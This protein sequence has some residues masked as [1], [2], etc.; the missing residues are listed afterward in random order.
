MPAG[1]TH[2]I[3]RTA[4]RNFVVMRSLTIL[5]LA[6]ATAGAVA[7][8]HSAVP[9][10]TAAVTPSGGAGTAAGRHPGEPPEAPAA[11][12]GLLGEYDAPAGM[13]IALE[14]GGRLFFADTVRHRAALS[15]TGEHQFTITNADARAVLGHDGTR[16]RFDVD[17]SGRATKAWLDDTPMAR[18]AI[19]PAPGT[20][21]LQVK[22]VRSVAE[23]RTEAL[24]ATPPHENGT[25]RPADLVELTSL[26]PTIRLE[27]RYATTNNFLGTKFYD[28]A[29]AFMQRP[30]AE[31]VVR[32]NASLKSLGYG[33]MI[34]DAYRPWYVTKMFWDATP[35]DRRW[36]VANPTSGSKHNR[37]CAVDLTLYDLQTGMPVEMPSTYDE[38]TDRAY[39][40][41]PGGT[42]AQRWRRAVLRRA[43]EA[44]GFKVNPT[45]WW[46][47]DYKDW[48]SYALGNVPFDQIGR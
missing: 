36:L 35:L 48:R 44:Q 42:T 21:Q 4:R 17:A 7:C 28:E 38:S 20:N 11:W 34:H 33:L 31:A 27:I 13:R 18:R 9:S 25:F 12:A 45:E 26:D 5:F 14:D 29:R 46:H 43:M 30:A 41:Y 15:A 2:G 19:E 3:E 47:F 39:A 6:S 24:A 10:T 16:V 37:G 23:I 40:D 22:P 8:T 32:A 1:A